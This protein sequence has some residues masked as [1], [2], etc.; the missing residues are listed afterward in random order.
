MILSKFYKTPLKKTQKY[1][2]R[3]FEDLELQNMSKPTLPE[4]DINQMHLG[5]GQ[6]FTPHMLEIDYSNQNGWESA[7]LKPLENLSLHPANSTLHYALTC[8]DGISHFEK[9]PD[10]INFKLTLIY[11]NRF[12]LNER[13]EGLQRQKWPHSSFP[14]PKKHGTIPDVL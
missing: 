2:F 10:F 14:S 6:I 9:S 3:N 1:F 12:F 7:I 11:L 13:I 5:F 4:T 8:Y